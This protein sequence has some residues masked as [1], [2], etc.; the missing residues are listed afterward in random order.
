MPVSAGS[1]PTQEPGPCAKRARLPH[2]AGARRGVRLYER[3]GRE[4]ADTG[5]Q[6]MQTGEAAGALIACPNERKRARD[7]RRL[8]D[9]QAR[10]YPTGRN[11]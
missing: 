5:V 1:R 11:R 4:L 7:E 10:A 6:L 3:R 2:R 9:D 8:S